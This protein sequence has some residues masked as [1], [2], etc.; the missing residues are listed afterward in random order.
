M[1]YSSLSPKPQPRN[2]SPPRGHPPHL[3]TGRAPKPVITKFRLLRYKLQRIGSETG[4]Y[5]SFGGYCKRHYIMGDSDQNVEIRS[6][7]RGC[8]GA[9]EGILDLPRKS[10]SCRCIGIPIGSGCEIDTL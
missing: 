9:V 1:F 2:L 6:E 5:G 10:C 7:G 3:T 4:Q 8:A